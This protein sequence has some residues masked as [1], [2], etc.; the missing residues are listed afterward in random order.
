VLDESSN[1]DTMVGKYSIIII[2]IIIIIIMG[3][4]VVRQ[5]K[6]RIFKT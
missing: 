1:L 2:I 5:K 3:L 4:H 6:K